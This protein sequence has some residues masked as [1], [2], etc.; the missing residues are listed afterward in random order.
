MKNYINITNSFQT[1]GKSGIQRVVKELV[2]RYYSDNKAILVV[3]Y[4][5]SLYCLEG[6]KEFTKYFSGRSFIPRKKIPLEVF[7]K[8][9]IFFDIDASWGD[10][11]DADRF[12]HFLKKSGAIIVKMHYD[13]VPV[14]FPEYAHP[15]TVFNFLENF[16]ASLKYSDY[17]LCISKVVEQDLLKL[18][19]SIGMGQPVSTVIPLGADFSSGCKAISDKRTYSEKFGKY[20]LIV[21]TIEPRK[22]HV[23]VIDVFEKMLAE[24]LGLKMIFVGKQGWKVDSTI[25]RIVNHKAYNRELF[26]FN[27]VDDADVKG[28]YHNAHLCKNVFCG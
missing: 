21:G 22:N 4:K 14:L 20:I 28:F 1:L 13:A 25:S 3:F 27:D 17:W 10:S 11:Y 19:K 16:S 8:G 23:L 24:G 7:R 6:E 5:R 18:S 9:D 15:N 26:W 12:F 2:L